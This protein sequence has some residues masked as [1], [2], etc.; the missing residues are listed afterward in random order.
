MSNALTSWVA[1]GSTNMA[2]GLRL[3]TDVM[4]I[5][6]N[7]DRPGVPNFAIVITDGR[8]DN[9]TASVAEAERLRAAGVVV[10]VVGVGDD[11]DLTELSLIASSPTASTVLLSSNGDG[12]NIG[13]DVTDRAA[14]IVCRNEQPCASAPCLNGGTCHDEVA[15]TFTCRCPDSFTGPRCE[16]G[17]GGRVDL[18]FVLDVSGSTRLER[19][20]HISCVF[21]GLPGSNALGRP[22]EVYIKCLCSDFEVLPT[23]NLS[24]GKLRSIVFKKVLCHVQ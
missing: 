8:S 15:G 10:I 20:A 9:K 19:S 7:G 12:S 5:R 22:I 2:D 13:V 14:H 24:K 21:D 4:F 3:A 6:A 23:D 18:V 11:V 1:S 17:C 16:R